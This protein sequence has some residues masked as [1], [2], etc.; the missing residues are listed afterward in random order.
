MEVCCAWGHE[1]YLPDFST[2]SGF[3]FEWN[4]FQELGR[5][6]KNSDVCICYS[7]L[8]KIVHISHASLM[9]QC[10]GIHYN[11]LIHPRWKFHTSYLWGVTAKFR[12]GNMRGW[13]ISF[14]V[15]T[16]LW[17]GWQRNQGLIPSRGRNISLPCGI[18][19]TLASYY[20]GTR[21]SD[22]DQFLSYVTYEYPIQ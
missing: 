3:I 5:Q 21:C 2:F 13:K 8:L 15:L 9:S 11:F 14:T 4:V 18:L 19:T 12:Y 10:I 17:T 20:L 1:D 6:Y 22:L 7:S 16:R